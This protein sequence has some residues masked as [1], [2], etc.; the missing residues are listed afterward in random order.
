VPDPDAPPVPD[1]IDPLFTPWS[2]RITDAATSWDL[3][4][5]F[6]TL[7]PTID[8]HWIV[9]GSAA[10]ALSKITNDGSVLWT[11]KYIRDNGTLPVPMTV[12]RA[13]QAYDL[14]IL[15]STYEPMGIMKLD[16]DGGV[17]KSWLADIEF[18]P[19][20]GIQAITPAGDGTYYVGAPFNAA[21]MGQSDALIF[22]MDDNGN[23]LWSKTWGR[24]TISE[25]VTS[26]L[27][28]DDDIIVIG[29]SFGLD[30][31]PAN[32]SWAMRLGPDGSTKWIKEIKGLP[33]TD[34][35]NLRR[36]HVSM[37]GDIIA[38]GNYRL[39]GPDVML[40]KIKPDGTLGWVSGNFGG[41]LGLDMTDFFQLSD[42]GY[43]MA[44]VWWTGG[45]DSL[46]IAR[47]DSVGTISWLKKY[48]DGVEDGSPSVVL[49]GDG[50]AMLAGY[51]D[52]GV[53]RHSTW[54]S[55]IP[56][57]TG[58]LPLDPAEA[59][60]TSEV[61]APATEPE[62]EFN[63]SATT[64]V[65]RPINLIEDPVTSTVLNPVIVKIHQ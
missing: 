10:Q 2:Y 1:L 41:G 63:D 53:D 27:L 25:W 65:D 58:E 4:R 28:L 37:N 8:G 31:D 33:G 21:D 11:R 34:G 26:I 7:E 6:M 61:S 14:G 29:Q 55:R 18:Q 51:T 20:E 50:G 54:I 36:A 35:V 16:A 60:I 12:N 13:A 38:G 17:V 44:G 9:A 64:L 47:T 23:V 42:G 5:D 56:I 22:K 62:L 40:V 52:K 15:A 45:T 59:T 30:Q 39:G 57:K 49:T 24:E 43:I 46:W 3:D 32:Q 48:A 19:V